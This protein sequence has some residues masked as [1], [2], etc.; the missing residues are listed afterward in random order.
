MSSLYPL[1]FTPVPKERVWGGDYIAKHIHPQFPASKTIG[2]SWELCGLEEN[3]SVV[4]NGFLKDNDINELIEVY[5]GD[6]VGDPVYQKFG[7]EFPLTVKILDI[8]DYLSFQVH[9]SD[10]IAMARHNAYGKAELWYI[11]HAEPDAKIYLGF[12]RPMTAAACEQR[13]LNQTLP[14]VMN[15]FTPRA[16]EHFYIPPGTVHAAGGGLVVAEVQQV[17]DITY[18]IYD[19]GREFHKETAREMHLDLAMD[20][21][22]WEPFLLPEP[23]PSKDGVQCLA[24]TPW[25]HIHKRTVVAPT[26]L[27]NTF[28][29]SFRLLTCVEGQMEV[30]AN[31]KV[32]LTKGESALIPATIGQYTVAPHKQPAHP[33]RTATPVSFL[34]THIP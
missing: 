5:M 15:E 30:T 19:W 20:A 29:S 9:P 28:G 22:H 13:C 3:I 23:Q 6:L 27:S 18:R 4:C 8:N 32:S 11:L 31:E 7:C 16:G 17:S 21:I 34:E 14:E 26:L 25:F 2:E 1:C 12:N 24:E 10:K 33:T